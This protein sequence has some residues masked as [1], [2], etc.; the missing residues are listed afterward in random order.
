MLLYDGYATLCICRDPQN[1]TAQRVNLKDFPGGP[2]APNAGG[3]SSISGQ[4]TRSHM[5]E[6]RARMMQL[7]IDLTCC[8]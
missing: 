6:L 5:L 7:K 8:N 1:F 2:G 4:G 3:L